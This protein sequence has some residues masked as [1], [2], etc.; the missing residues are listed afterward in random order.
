MDSLNRHIENFTRLTTRLKMGLAKR[1]AHMDQFLKSDIEEIIRVVDHPATR[2]QMEACRGRIRRTVSELNHHM[3]AL[4][5]LYEGMEV[6][7]KAASL[8]KP[9]MQ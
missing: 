3:Q 1:I 8:S 5:R 2:S 4:E 7:R 9:S 6:D